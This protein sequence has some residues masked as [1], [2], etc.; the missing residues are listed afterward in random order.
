MLAALEK[1]GSMATPR[2][3]LIQAL[4][5]VEEAAVPEDL[6]EVAF[7]KSF[8]LRAGTTG[9]TT[10]AQYPAPPD[11]G[12]TRP[13]EQRAGATAAGD[14]LASIAERLKIDRDTVAEVFTSEDGEPELII[15]PTKLPEKAATGTKEIALL[16]AGARQA[17]GIE[18][19]T[20]TDE[21]RKAC[22]DYKRYDQANF[23]STIHEMGDVFNSRK[24]SPRKTQVRLARPGWER[25][26][27]A[28]RR[29]GGG[30]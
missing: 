25:L 6:R 5:D 2:E 29:L 20:S 3:V 16:I 26:A 28:I 17:A 11:G 15:S 21:I 13:S 19:W 12:S 23:A 30:E 27:A 10:Q 22:V 18:D 9:A 1:E 7:S 14:V 24:E 8:D 4:K